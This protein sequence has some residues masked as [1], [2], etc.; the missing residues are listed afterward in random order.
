MHKAARISA[1]VASTA[2]A[3]SALATP[4]LADGEVME[5]LEIL[6]GCCPDGR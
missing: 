2:L 5:L 4:V 1:L 3:A 6:E